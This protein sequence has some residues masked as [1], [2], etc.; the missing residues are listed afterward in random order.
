[1][2]PRSAYR[3]PRSSPVSA[4]KFTAYAPRSRR[5]TSSATGTRSKRMSVWPNME[6]GLFR[7]ASAK[8]ML[9]ASAGPTSAR[10][11]SYSGHSTRGRRSR[12]KPSTPSSHVKR[13]GY[14]QRA[15]SPFTK[16][17]RVA[18][19]SASGSLAPRAARKKAS[20]RA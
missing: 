2:M 13:A 14:R 12:S 5:S 17:A 9:A 1:M 18:R 8:T 19:S 16:A 7:K 3:T 20:E 4:A 15:G 11:W 10:H 6:D